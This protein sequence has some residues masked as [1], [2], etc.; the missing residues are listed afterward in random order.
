MDPQLTLLHPDARGRSQHQCSPVS[1]QHNGNSQQKSFTGSAKKHQKNFIAAKLTY[2]SYLL[3][4]CTRLQYSNSVDN[5]MNLSLVLGIGLKNKIDS[6]FT[7]SIFL[8]A[9]R[10]H[11]NT[12][13]HVI[14]NL[15]MTL[16]CE[17]CNWTFH[18]SRQDTSMTNTWSWTTWDSSISVTT[19][20]KTFALRK[21]ESRTPPLRTPTH[22]Q[23]HFRR[24]SSPQA[25]FGHRWNPTKLT[26]LPMSTRP[27]R[28]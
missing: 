4:Y 10:H 23:S 26:P 16:T 15:K 5:T 20:R 24:G 17:A 11:R 9:P 13:L 7:L 25:I 21:T 12:Q 18:C 28:I 8:D 1:T 6:G 3:W 22:R 2:L 27:S 14:L 19:V